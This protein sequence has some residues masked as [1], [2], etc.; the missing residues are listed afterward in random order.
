MTR[1]RGI[2]GFFALVGLVLA[3]RLALTY[4]AVPF[5]LV[6][7]GSIVVTAIFLALPIL[8][9]YRGADD[10]WN[11]RVALTFLIGGLATH[12]GLAFVAKSSLTG[13]PQVLALTLSQGGML[14]WCVGLGALI[15]TLIKERNIVLPIGIFLAAY[16]MFL[17]LTPLGMTRQIMEKAP[18]VLPNVAWS[19]PKVATTAPTGAPLHDL[20]FI[21]PADFIFM[22]MFFVVLFRFGMRTR[23]TLI[24]LTPTLLGY[25]AIVLLLGDVRIGSATLGALPALV[26][27]GACVLLVNRS[28]FKLNKDEKL[29]TIVLAVLAIGA[30]IWGAT[31]PVP[32]P[33]PLP[34]DVSTSAPESANSPAPKAPDSRP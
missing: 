17:V 28:E 10:T 7:L 12:F 21:G 9:I 19:I 33:A 24:W 34:M 6:N 22:G 8:A 1:L 20:A 29:S 5:G 11:P 3:L 23:E 32:P 13:F 30:V 18:K 2:P 14:T 31:R 26:P 27:I 25:L 16:D 15:A 4:V